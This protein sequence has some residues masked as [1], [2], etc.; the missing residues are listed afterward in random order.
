MMRHTI[1]FGYAP[2][3]QGR[4]TDALGQWEMIDSG[5]KTAFIA[6]QHQVLD[7]AV[8][9]LNASMNAGSDINWILADA[10]RLLDGKSV[11]GN[12]RLVKGLGVLSDYCRLSLAKPLWE[13]GDYGAGNPFGVYDFQAR[14]RHN[15]FKCPHILPS[16]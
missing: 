9:Q 1:I 12:D 13:T 2:A 8:K 10:G 6:Q 16:G 14:S 4:Y 11:H 15:R 3:K 7:L 5:D